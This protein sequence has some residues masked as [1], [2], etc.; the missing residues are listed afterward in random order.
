M[1]DATTMRDATVIKI[2]SHGSDVVVQKKA[3]T[4]YDRNS[5]KT[6]VTDGDAHNI[7]AIIERYGSEEIQGLIQVG[8]IKLMIAEH[9][10]NFDIANDVLKFNNNE[11]NIINISPFIYKNVA[12]Y[13]SLQVR[14]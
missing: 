13:Y 11:Y 7:K 14:R 8:D 6:I 10:I 4:T 5:G 2:D 12:I 9:N 3:S 1:A